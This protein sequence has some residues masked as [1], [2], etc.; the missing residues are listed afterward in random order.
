MRLSHRVRSPHAG[1]VPVVP[2]S[3]VNL[4][5]RALVGLLLAGAPPSS[6]ASEPPVG[7]ADGET[8]VFVGD[9]ITRAGGYHA[10]VQL[11]YATRHPE[12]TIRF[13]N[14]GRS[15]DAAPATLRRLDWDVLAH[16]PTRAVV[17]LGMNDVGHGF[18]EAGPTD[19]AL[20]EAVARR[21]DTVAGNYE[22]LLAA[23][24]RAGPR[25]TLVG[26]SI[27]DETARVERPAD[28]GRARALGEWAERVAG[29][30][31]RHHADF[32][33][34]QAPMARLNAARQETDPAF[35]LVGP[36]RIHPGAVGHFVM[37]HL[38]LRS[39]GHPPHVARVAIDAAR[40]ALI[41]SVGCTVENLDVTAGVTTFDATAAALPM[42][43][44]PDAVPALALVPFHAELNQEVLQLTGLPRGRHGLWI[45]GEPVGEY[46]A[47]ALAEGVNLATNART[48]QYRQ[49]MA[50]ARANARRHRIESGDLRGMAWVRSSIL[51]PA[52][53]DADDA[54][55]V[56]RAFAAYRG[57][58]PDP[59]DFGLAMIAKW[60]A[61]RA[62]RERTAADLDDAIAAMRREG[63][64][65]RRRWVVRPV[66][67]TYGLQGQ[68]VDTLRERSRAGD[69][70][71][72]DLVALIRRDADRLAAAPLVAVT[73]KPEPSPGGDRH[74]YVSLA[75]YYWPN[76]KTPDGLP[77]VSRDGEV[78]PEGD[79]YDKGRM[80]TM[81][82]AVQGLALAHHLTGEPAYAERAARQIRGW[83][84][85]DA[86][87]MNPHLKYGQLV[88]GRTEGSPFGIID[89]TALTRVL[90]AAGLLDG[91]DAWTAADR[92]RLQDWFRAYLE[93]LTT[94]DLGRRE[95]EDGNNHGV[96]YDVQ[97]ASFAMFVGEPARARAIVEAAKLRRIAA[98]IEPDGSMPRE[99]KRT[100]SLGYTYHNLR[101]LLRLAALG[102]R[103]GVDLWGWQTADGRGIRG[104]CDF[105]APYVDPAKPWPYRQIVESGRGGIATLLHLADSRFGDAPYAK[106]LDRHAGDRV[107]KQRDWLLPD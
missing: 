46:G 76:P 10:L 89:T 42:P 67:D 81:S 106:I 57:K 54:E 64:P 93:W 88:R 2:G 97:T 19:T 96:W 44:P 101:A 18:P 105:V 16:R 34:F 28:R 63:R 36:D 49:A 94:S 107:R 86:T 78:N 25:L 27:Y 55:G 65:R 77:Y 23:L 24:E 50:V 5:I 41:E 9:S 21:L 83:F 39:Q 56:E 71:A 30:A 92:A 75:V 58:H 52:G 47:E 43:V 68:S 74:D 22:R 8:V 82:A 40:P 62:A 79:A 103:L 35:S 91:S 6:R 70:A 17:M 3:L 32:V 7:F 59:K 1:I 90:D 61:W 48:P 100:K 31:Q 99:L 11:F 104:A 29:I 98:Q 45:D 12:R 66:P 73:D 84:F 87:R 69:P 33:D 85:D 13:F 20:D 14:A 60:P 37:G 15:G 80:E 53:V 4:L 51:E 95:S 38:F 26:P 72:R 102:E